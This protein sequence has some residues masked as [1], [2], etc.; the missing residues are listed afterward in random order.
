ME[1]WFWNIDPSAQDYFSSELDKGTL[2]QGWGYDERLKLSKLKTKTDDHIAFDDEEQRAW[3]RCNTML[4][5]IKEGD[6]I[7]VKNVPTREQ[8]TIVEVKGSYDYNIEDIGD[9]GH[10]LPVKLKKLKAKGVKSAVDC[11]SVI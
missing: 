3:D 9:Y 7:V 4:L 10:I 1:C 8:F 5:Y 11:Y 2:R 6:L